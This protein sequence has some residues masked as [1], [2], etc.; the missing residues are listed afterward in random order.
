MYRQIHPPLLQ[1]T[2]RIDRHYASLLTWYYTNSHTRYS[3][4]YCPACAGALLLSQS[5]ASPLLLSTAPCRPTANRPETL[6]VARSQ[7]TSTLHIG[8][9]ARCVACWRTSKLC[10]ELLL[11]LLLLSLSLLS[12]AV[13]V[14]RSRASPMEEK[15]RKTLRSLKNVDQVL[16]YTIPQQSPSA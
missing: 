10:K 9:V 8:H 5:K 13:Q 2:I 4:S 16:E 12:H 7:M 3:T 14:P 11:L 15:E 1:V 6:F